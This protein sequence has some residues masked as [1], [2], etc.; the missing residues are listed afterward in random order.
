MAS[1]ARGTDTGTG[2][3]DAITANAASHPSACNIAASQREGRHSRRQ[4]ADAF[5]QC[6]DFVIVGFFVAHQPVPEPIVFGF[7]KP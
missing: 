7:Q 6:L 1:T 3:S 5:D 2:N 4:G